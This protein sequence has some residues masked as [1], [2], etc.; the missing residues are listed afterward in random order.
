MTTKGY[1]EV[2]KTLTLCFHWLQIWTVLNLKVKITTKIKPKTQLLEIHSINKKLSVLIPRVRTKVLDKI[3]NKYSKKWWQ[4]QKPY[5]CYTIAIWPM[6]YFM[7]TT[8]P[9]SSVQM[10]NKSHPLSILYNFLRSSTRAILHFWSNWKRYK[11][12]W[13]TLSIYQCLVLGLLILRE[14]GVQHRCASCLHTAAAASASSP[15][16]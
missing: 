3:L 9:N 7:H 1:D 12:K 4:D 16:L 5:A 2:I 10:T 15:S 11:L 6:S 13:N 14:V 8:C